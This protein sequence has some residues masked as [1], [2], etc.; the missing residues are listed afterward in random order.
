MTKVNEKEIGLP[1]LPSRFSVLFQGLTKA[2]ISLW[3]TKSRRFSFTDI[4]FDQ[5]N[6][7]ITA[8]HDLVSVLF[9]SR[10]CELH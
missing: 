9:K 4:V 8:Q 3:Q 7:F 10:R 2:K 5:K 6:I 1:T